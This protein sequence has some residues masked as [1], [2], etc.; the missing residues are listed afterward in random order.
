MSLPQSTSGHWT[1]DR[2]S[3]VKA[4][5]LLSIVSAILV[6]AY[7]PFLY[8]NFRF[9]YRRPHY[10]YFPVMFVAVGWMVYQ[11]YY[12]RSTSTSLLLPNFCRIASYVAASI[13]FFMAVALASPV[14]GTCSFIFLIGGLIGQRRAA[15]FLPGAFAIWLLL[16]F[17]IPIPLQ[18]DRILISSLQ[19]LSAKVSSNLLDQIPVYHMMRGN[20]LELP[21]RRLFVDEACSGIT[22]LISFQ[23]FALSYGVFRRRHW[24][25]LVILSL[26]AIF[27]AFLVNVARVSTIAMMLQK[28]GIDLTSGLPHEVIG[29]L[30]L[31]VGIISV[32]ALDQVMD[33]FNPGSIRTQVD[34]TSPAVKDKR[35][36]GPSS[37]ICPLLLRR[38]FLSASVFIAVFGIYNTY[39]LTAGFDSPR[40]AVSNAHALKQSDLPAQADGWNMLAY[41]SVNRDTDHPFGEYSKTYAYG[42]YGRQAIFSFDYPFFGDWH[43]LTGCYRS[44]G[45]KV[46]HQQTLKGNANEIHGTDANTAWDSYAAEFTNKQGEHGYLMFCFVA[47]D[48]NAVDVP[49]AETTAFIKRL[50]SKGR[51]PWERTIY[52][53]QLWTTSPNKFSEADKAKLRGLYEQL[54]ES[55]RTAFSGD[56][57]TLTGNLLSRDLESFENIDSQLKANPNTAL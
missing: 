32:I 46:G 57:N 51:H 37:V 4:I 8:G 55:A 40:L 24:W 16:W 2:K 20:V 36:A 41:D 6:V 3:E 26:S 15:G 14:L 45:W 39:I 52:Q 11:R 56:S 35:S 44:S 19:S 23:A 22:S 38:S 5:A 17:T 33:A 12:E 1:K 7:G 13:F 30:L 49:S 9:M 43:D 34:L 18:I 25:H 21:D 42:G 31:A 54:R 50:M 10:S 27:F 29:L 28:Y 47:E 53:I 48:G